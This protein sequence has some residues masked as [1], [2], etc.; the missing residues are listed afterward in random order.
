MP[1]LDRDRQRGGACRPPVPSQTRP[2][3]SKP[4]LYRHKTTWLDLLNE[5]YRKGSDAPRRQP[6]FGTRGMIFLGLGCLIA[7]LMTL[8]QVFTPGCLQF[9][10]KADD[11]YTPPYWQEKINQ[12]RSD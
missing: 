4:R 11:A 10:Y 12:E 6:T 9:D 8:T 3:P 5:D 7:A 2:S 1:H